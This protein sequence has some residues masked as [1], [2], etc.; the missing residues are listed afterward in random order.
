MIAPLTGVVVALRSLLVQPVGLA[1]RGVKV[2]RQWRVL[3]SRSCG[4]GTCKQFTAH[5]VQLAHR[6]PPEAAQEGPQSVRCLH[7]TA[8]H[9]LDI[10]TAQRVRIVY[11]VA[12][13]QCRCH[14]GHQL[15]SRVRPT[16]CLPKVKAAVHKLTQTQMMGKSDR[17]QQSC[18]GHQAGIVEGYADALGTL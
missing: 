18:I 14:Q 16:W 3:G 5:T 1:D 9:P 10:T 11:A 17:Q 7:R 13:P 15:V 8:Q 2:D 12:S 6:S 4:P